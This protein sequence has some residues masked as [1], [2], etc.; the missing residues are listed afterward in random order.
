MSPVDDWADAA[1]EYCPLSGLPIDDIITQML[2]AGLSLAEIGHLERLSDRRV[3]KRIPKDRLPEGRPH[4][5]RNSRADLVLY[6]DAWAE[7]LTEEADALAA[8]EVAA[9][10]TQTVVA[11]PLHASSG[12]ETRPDVAAAGEVVVPALAAE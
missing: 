4:L 11:F 7:L 9:S 8:D 3:L 2:D 6:L 12:V 1:I 5:R 10:E